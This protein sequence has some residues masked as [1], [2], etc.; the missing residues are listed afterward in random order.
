MGKIYL[1]GSSLRILRRQVLASLQAMV[2][3][4]SARTS[5]AVKQL[6]TVDTGSNI[7]RIQVASVPFPGLRSLVCFVFPKQEGCVITKIGNC[8]RHVLNQTYNKT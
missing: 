5:C 4:V 7:S 2:F 3:H 8:V 1:S 6:C